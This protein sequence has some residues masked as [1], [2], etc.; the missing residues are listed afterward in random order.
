MRVSQT[1]FRTNGSIIEEF[2]RVSNFKVTLSDT[3]NYKGYLNK[4]GDNRYTVLA[5]SIKKISDSQLR[6]ESCAGK[7]YL[8]RNM[9]INK[10][11]E[12]LFIRLI[13][14][15]AKA[16]GG[17]ITVY[18]VDYITSYNSPTAITGYRT[19]AG[20]IYPSELLKLPKQSSITFTNSDKNELISWYETAKAIFLDPEAN[21]SKKGFNNEILKK[22]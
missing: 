4:I 14:P 22:I 17:K 15:I 7:G 9:I 1:F 3:P 12:K 5:E 8:S 19:N 13:N 11:S 10:E 6:V 21:P 18:S 20:N 16:L 2:K